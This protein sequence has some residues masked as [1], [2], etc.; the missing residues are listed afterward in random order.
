MTATQMAGTA[1]PRLSRPALFLLLQLLVLVAAWALLGGWRSGCRQ[2]GGAQSRLQAPALNGGGGSR[3]AYPHTSNLTGWA[4][5]PGEL[6]FL[7]PQSRCLLDPRGA[8][9]CG[10]RSC[11][12]CGAVVGLVVPAC[13]HWLHWSS[14]TPALCPT[15]AWCT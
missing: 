7:A 9:L 10:W 6:A 8:A 13:R 1:L 3:D 12:G 15:Q 14:H 2:D 11:G 5:A 4:A